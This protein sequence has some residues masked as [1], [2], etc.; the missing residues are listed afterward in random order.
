MQSRFSLKG[1][2]GN[3]VHAVATTNAIA[4]GL[5]VLEAF[6]VLR[7][8]WQQCRTCWIKRTGPKVPSQP[9]NVSLVLLG[10]PWSSLV[11]SDPQPSF[12]VPFCLVQVLQPCALAPPNPACAV[13]RRQWLVLR[14]DTASF[15]LQQLYRLVLR[16]ALAM[17]DPDLDVANRNNAVGVEEDWDAA[18]LARPLAAARIDDG[19]ELSVL[20]QS[21]DYTARIVVRH[22]YASP[23]STLTTHP[24]LCHSATDCVRP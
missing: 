20:D 12:V 1:I 19:A 16:Q 9:S 22:T 3:I 14:V 2:A 17:N 6:K 13:C 24:T 11:H 4:A 18:F 8:R 23:T 15:T 7:G 21:Q 5:I 10:P